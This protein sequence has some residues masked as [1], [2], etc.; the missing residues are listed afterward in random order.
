MAR[1]ESNREASLFPKIYA[2]LLQLH[3]FNF[4]FAGLNASEE[5][6]SKSHGAK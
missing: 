3:S 1:H 2:T 6:S 4:S 5:L